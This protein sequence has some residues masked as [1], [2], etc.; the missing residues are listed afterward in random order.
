VQGGAVV[1]VEVDPVFTAHPAF[2]ITA[3][4]IL[5]WNGHPALT[6]GIHGVGA[7]DVVGTTL[8]QELTGPKTLT[9]SVGKGTWT[10]SGVWKLPA[11]FF[12][13]D[14]TTDRWLSTDGNT[15][16]G[17]SVVGAH[18]IAH[19]GGAEG[20]YNTFFGHSAGNYLTTGS[21]N[22]AIGQHALFY[23]SSGV[24][25]IGVGALAGNKITTGSYNVAIGNLA[26][27]TSDSSYGLF[28]DNRETDNPLIGGNFTER[29][30]W[31]NGSLSMKT[32]QVNDVV[33]PTLA[34]DAAT[35]NYVDSRTTPAYGELYEDSTPGTD[36]TVVTNGTY[37]QWVSSTVGSFT[38]TTPSAAGDNITADAGGGGTY[39]ASFSIAYSTVG[40]DKVAHWAVFKNGVK[41]DNISCE[42]KTKSATI[43]H[44][45]SSGFISLV[46]TDG[47]DLRVTS[48]TDGEVIT[49]NHANLNIVRVG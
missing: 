3:A 4:N 46:A 41:Q 1:V 19:T 12:N 37:Y 35:K 15:F 36:I 20:W 33:D 13:G 34:Q 21:F 7:G 5:A 14:V 6:T 45:S 22:T 18:A 17:D 43:T 38:L 29:K 39:Q 40:N 32:N 28:I 42:T 16:F 10:A 48:D 9:N 31:I 8:I 2:G 44:S 27:P 49:V 24:S 26:G 47:V 25:N 23:L 30:A 11:M